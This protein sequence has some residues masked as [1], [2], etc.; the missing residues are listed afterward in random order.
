MTITT[1][2]RLDR[3]PL[4]PRPR[5]R[6]L[7]LEERVMELMD[8]ISAPHPDDNHRRATQAAEVFNKAA[9]IAS[10]A[11]IPDMARTL[12]WRQHAIYEKHGSLPEWAAPLVLQPLLNLVRQVIRDEDGSAAH[13]LL[14]TLL[15]AAGPAKT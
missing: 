15:S 3:F 9:L 10:D 5:P 6:A 11:D 7:S 4:V 2:V 13:A 14:E 12:C 8:I 1:N